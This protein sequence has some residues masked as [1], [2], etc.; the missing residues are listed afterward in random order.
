MSDET[1][2]CCPKCG[3]SEGLVK[4]LTTFTTSHRTS[5]EAKVGD[6]TEQFIEDAKQDLKHQKGE[7]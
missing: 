6:V 7:T 5:P 4:I 1:E 3:D 2:T